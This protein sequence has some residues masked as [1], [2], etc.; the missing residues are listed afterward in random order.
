MCPQFSSTASDLTKSNIPLTQDDI[1]ESHPLSLKK[2][3][4]APRLSHLFNEL[5]GQ[6]EFPRTNG[7]T[8]MNTTFTTSTMKPS[9][10]KTKD[11]NT[12]PNGQSVSRRLSYFFYTSG[13][14]GDLAHAVPHGRVPPPP[15]P[16]SLFSA[17]KRYT[18]QRETT[19]NVSA[20]SVA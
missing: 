1:T 18:L 8:F 7:Y 4:L 9:P 6:L 10:P 16:P 3:P 11:N 19:L 12:P 20:G 15:P 14:M 17:S 13:A 2:I 5:L